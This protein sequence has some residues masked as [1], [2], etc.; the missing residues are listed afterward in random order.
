MT[1]NRH[2]QRLSF[3]KATTPLPKPMALESQNSKSKIVAYQDTQS[4]SQ[5]AAE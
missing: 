1:I 5:E 2:V 3:A 4:S